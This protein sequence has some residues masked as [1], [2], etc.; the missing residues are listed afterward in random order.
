[1]KKFN[2]ENWPVIVN[3]EEKQENI[4]SVLTALFS[5][6][7]PSTLP[8]GFAQAVMFNRFLTAFKEAETSKEL[9]LD[10][11]DYDFLKKLVEEET[12]AVWGASPNVMK[13]LKDFVGG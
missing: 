11:V 12:P 4:V 6:K 10:D 8:R 2:V 3:G 7:D 1:M 5:H 13:A 9:V